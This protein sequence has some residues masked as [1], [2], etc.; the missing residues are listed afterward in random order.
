MIENK[1]EVKF[2]DDA[3]VI[4]THKQ[5]LGF[6]KDMEEFANPEE[7]IKIL[8]IARKFRMSLQYM[9]ISNAP[10]AI[11][12]FTNAIESN[13]YDIAFYLLKVYEDEIYQNY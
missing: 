10:F 4:F 8:I 12:Y 9:Q 6:L 7:I 13:S 5:I 3:P 11:E 2:Q 1:R